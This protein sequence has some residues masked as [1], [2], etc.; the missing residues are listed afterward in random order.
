MRWGGGMQRFFRKYGNIA[1]N[2]V[3]WLY[4]PKI[5]IW[6]GLRMK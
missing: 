6:G 3:N 5:N 2:M 4:C 1:S